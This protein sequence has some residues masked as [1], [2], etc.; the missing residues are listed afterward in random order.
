LSTAFY[1]QTDGQTERL[2]QT[3]EQYLQNYVNQKQDNWIKLLPAV[4]FVY[5]STKS[6]STKTTPFFAN[7]RYKPKAY[8]QLK[9]DI[10]IA[11]QAIVLANNIQDLYI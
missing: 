4:Q 8:Y 6:E 1:L 7:Y 11:E 10:N 9:K 2:N 5:N 3:L